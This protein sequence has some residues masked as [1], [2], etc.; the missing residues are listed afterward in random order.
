MASLLGVRMPADEDGRSVAGRVD[1][2][3]DGLLL[4]GRDGAGLCPA[5]EDISKR[6]RFSPSTVHGEGTI[7]QC[8]SPNVGLYMRC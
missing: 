2:L 7:G 6:D 3:L 4:P 5:T 1:A 8:Q